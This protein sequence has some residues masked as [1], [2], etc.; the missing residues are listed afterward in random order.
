MEE[1]TFSRKRFEE[2]YL[3]PFQDIDYVFWPEKGFI[4]WRNGTGGNAELLHIRS[5]KFKKGYARQ[6]IAEMV[7]RL[8]EK[9][10]YFS[11]FGFGLSNRIE[12]KEI[13]SRLGFN[14]TENMIPPYKKS[15]SF[16]FWQDFEKLKEK[17][18][19]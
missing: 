16:I 19:Q 13:Y 8:S 3:K 1:L 10:P 17:Y 12:L 14:V 7:R 11:V 18:S 6:L 15:Q 2:K 5:F 9:P 4:V